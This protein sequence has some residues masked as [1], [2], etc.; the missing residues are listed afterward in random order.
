MPKVLED[1]IVLEVAESHS[2]TAAQ[3]LLRHLIQSG[4]AVI[5]KSASPR[6][7][8]E[9][10]DVIA[11]QNLFSIR[12]SID[13]HHFTLEKKLFDFVLSPNEMERLDGLD[14]KLRTFNFHE[15]RIP[16]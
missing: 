14:R 4:V 3:I 10:L 5:P 16:G 6:R 15:F 1:P 9:N 8:R 2:K 12:I 7:I 11:R 13:K